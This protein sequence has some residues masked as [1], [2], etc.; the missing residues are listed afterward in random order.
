MRVVYGLE[1]KGAKRKHSPLLLFPFFSRHN[2]RV[3]TRSET[4]ALFYY[5]DTSVLL[6]NIPLVKFIKTTSGT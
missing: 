1:N 5:I 2:F 3:I 6:E 4:F